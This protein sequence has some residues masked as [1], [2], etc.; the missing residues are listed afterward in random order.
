MTDHKGETI[1]V[2]FVAR[3]NQETADDGSERLIC[4][5]MNWRAEPEGPSLPPVHL[6][7]QIVEGLG[8]PGEHR[9]LVDPVHWT[10]LKWLD[11]PAPFFDWHARETGRQSVHPADAI[12]M[13]RMTLE[14]ANGSTSGVLRLRDNDSGWTPVHLTANRIELEPDTHAALM[15]FRLPTEAELD[16]VEFAEEDD[17]DGS[18]E[19]KPRKVKKRKKDKPKKADD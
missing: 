11:D 15:T 16:V 8:Q 18:A 13:A 19:S 3:A 4:R 14:F 5:A 1:S 6:A 2:G 17:I 10:L 9:A 7:E 12:H